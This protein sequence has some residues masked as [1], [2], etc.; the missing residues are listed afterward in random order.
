VEAAAAAPVVRIAAPA[1]VPG[2]PLEGSVLREALPLPHEALAHAIVTRARA[3]P[4]NGAVEVRFALE[5]ADL[6]AVRVE[7]ETRGRQVRIHIE[8]ATEAAASVL[9]PGVARLATDL[10]S[11]GYPDPHVSVSTSPEHGQRETLP[12]GRNGTP[13]EH[14][15]RETSPRREERRKDGRLDR[16]A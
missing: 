6:G 1:H 8:T 16:T 4:E 13:P 11:A 5:P 9:S 15:E 14:G 3:L 2:A 10:H 7:I 12:N